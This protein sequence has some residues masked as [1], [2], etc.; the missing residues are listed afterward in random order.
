VDWLVRRQVPGL[1]R[2]SVP[3]SVHT[4]RHQGAVS[5]LGMISFSKM[6]STAVPC[7]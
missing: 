5:R 7:H 4:Q 2:M 3:C 6:P 1:Y